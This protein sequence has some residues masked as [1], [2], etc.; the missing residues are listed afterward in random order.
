MGMNIDEVYNHYVSLDP[1]KNISKNAAESKML[2]VN[3]SMFKSITK[4]VDVKMAEFKVKI[5]DQF[6]EVAKIVGNNNIVI[7]LGKRDNFFEAYD[8]IIINLTEE[9][10]QQ[11]TDHF[12]NKGIDK[13]GYFFLVVEFAIPRTENEAGE[14]NMLTLMMKHLPKN[15]DPNEFFGYII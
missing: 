11:I 2:T 4:L 14:D 6:T 10:L 7:R 8:V 3:Y 12:R 5:F 1:Q 15:E 9:K 13:E